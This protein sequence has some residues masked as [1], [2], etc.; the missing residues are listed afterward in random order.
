MKFDP[1]AHGDG[2]LL[3]LISGKRMVHSL[4]GTCHDVPKGIAVIGDSNRSRTA[5]GIQ[6][7]TIAVIPVRKFGSGHRDQGGREVTFRLREEPPIL[8]IE[9]NWQIWLL[10]GGIL[11]TKRLQLRR[12]ELDGAGC[13]L[14]KRPPWQDKDEQHPDG[15]RP[16]GHEIHPFKAARLA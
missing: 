12:R 6:G 3:P 16:R 5:G 7:E 4:A 10:S 14:T 9:T 8:E 13:L 15:S 2:R 11:A 1:I